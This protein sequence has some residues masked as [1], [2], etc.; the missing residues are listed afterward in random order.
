MTFTTHST[1]SKDGTKIGYRQIGNG[2]G[3]IIC[4]GGGRISQNYESLAIALSDSFKVYIPDR[5]GRGLSEAE[6]ENYDIHKATEDL[7]AVIQTT[8]AD[9]IFGHSAGAMIALETML[10]HPVKRLAVYELPIS[11]N[12]SFPL[13]WLTGFQIAIQKGKRKKAMA[14]SLKGLNIVEGIGKMP[15]WVINLLLN[16]L[17]LF[18]R[19]KDKGTRMVDLIPTLTAD[20]KMIAE[21]DSTIEQYQQINIPVSLM[22]GSKSPKYFHHGLQILNKNLKQS[23][24]II[25]DNLDHNSPE[26]KNIQIVEQLKKY[27]A[28]SFPKAAANV[29][30]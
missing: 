4:H 21:L 18:E 30:D 13:T 10:T 17:S 2:Q 29:L 6:G 8:S 23:D 19:K 1:T 20:I 7:I 14:I 24:I 28:S 25:F 27:F 5:R 11:I 22:A 9:F 16:V 12:H 26:G 15:V 3:L